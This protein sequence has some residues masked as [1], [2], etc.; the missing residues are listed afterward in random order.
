MSNLTKSEKQALNE[1]FLVLKE[2]ENILSRVKK[3]SLN[4]INYFIRLKKTKHPI[5]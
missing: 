5:I 4:I 1:L 3:I 2:N